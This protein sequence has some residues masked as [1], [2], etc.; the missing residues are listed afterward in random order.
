MFWSWLIV[1][2]SE[3][4]LLR[5]VVSFTAIKRAV[6]YVKKMGEIERRAYVIKIR[7]G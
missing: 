2:A 6:R 4:L 5:D 1:V 3:E 7:G